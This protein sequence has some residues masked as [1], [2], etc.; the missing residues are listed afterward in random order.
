MKLELSV[1]VPTFNESGNIEPLY[2]E[3]KKSLKGVKYEI[4]FV[5]DDSKDGTLDE[6]KELIKHHNNIKLIHRVDKRGLSSACIAGFIESNSKYLAV[7]DA[8]LQHDPALLSEMLQEIRSDKLDIVI[9]SRFLKDSLISGLSHTREKFSS[10]GN[11]LSIMVTGI[12]LSDPLSGYFM[13]KNDFVSPLIPK[14]SGMGFKILLDIISTSRFSRLKLKYLELPTHFRERTKGESK[15]DL[16]TFLEFV[17][18]ILDK[19]LGKYIPIRLV[20]FVIVGFSGLL[21]HMAALTI[22]LKTFNLGFVFSQILATAL[23][24]VSNF[25]INNIFTYRDR[26]L[27]GAAMLKGLISFCIACSVGG[28]VN[29]ASST[30]IFDKGVYWPIAALIGCVIGSV[31]NY[32]ATSLTTWKQKL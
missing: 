32:A 5:D 17:T 14:L 21:V 29:V 27:Y 26:R 16:L 4:I 19:I 3:I 2:N 6:I 12:K 8:D 24:M 23:A 1:I 15:L 31:I 9:A 18:L 20:L 25:F 28:A 11:A 30:F 22:L 10:I 13:I 7:I